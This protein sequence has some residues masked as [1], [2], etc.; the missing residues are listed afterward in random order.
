MPS[1]LTTLLRHCLDFAGLFPP[2][3]LGVS[4]ALRQFRMEQS[5]SPAEM[6]ARFVCPVLRLEELAAAAAANT[7]PKLDVAVLPRGGKSTGEFLANLETDLATIQRVAQLHGNGVTID[8]IE[9]RPPTDALPQPAL[10]KLVS[11]VNALLARRTSAVR[12]VFIEL[13]PSPQL[14]SQLEILAEQSVHGG[15]EP[16]LT[17][18][19]KLRTGGSDAVA[20]PSP[21]QV[22]TALGAVAALHLPM[23]CTG[24][25]H[26]PL[27][28]QG[29]NPMHGFI[30]L[31]VAAAFAATARSEPGVVEAVLEETD[32]TAFAFDARNVTW[33][34]HRLTANAVARGREEL[35]FSFG[36]CYADQSRLELLKLGWW[37]KPVRARMIGIGD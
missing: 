17:V 36:S 30:N 4:D 12:Q 11:S 2:A 1:T 19:Y 29:A 23:K 18:G 21:A 8:T 15:T 22:A 20:A 34:E 35:L 3:S 37:P 26:R 9:L 33:R 24:G 10:R 6:L 5:S 16:S 31:L 7:E 28:S 27:R 25:L 13:A 32:P 14:A